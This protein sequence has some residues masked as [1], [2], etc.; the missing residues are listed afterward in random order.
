MVSTLYLLKHGRGE[1]SV[2]TNLDESYEEIKKSA[3]VKNGT[4]AIRGINDTLKCSLKD[5]EEVFEQ[6]LKV[7][8]KILVPKVKK[9]S[10][11]RVAKK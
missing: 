8:G 5:A 10:M 2:R 4:N 1:Y 3:P 11:R 9:P 7:G 6:C